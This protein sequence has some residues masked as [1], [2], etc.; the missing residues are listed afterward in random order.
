M[1]KEKR[2][3]LDMLELPH[4]MEIDL[5]EG[6]HK[7][8]SRQFGG[9]P[10]RGF[11]ELIQNALDS[12]PS[13][14]PWQERRF[15]IETSTRKIMI[16][17]YGEGL[18]LS[19][20]KLL[21]TLG[22]TDKRNDPT[23]IGT[24][25]IGF[26]SIFNPGLGTK[27]VIVTTVCKGYTIEMVFTVKNPKKRPKITTRILEKKL[28]FSTRIDVR[29]DSQDAPDQC[30]RYARRSLKYYPCSV[31]I[32]GE[33]FIS[34]WS[35][36]EGSG[37]R[38]FKMN[39][40]D[41]FLYQGLSRRNVTLLCKYEYI[42]NTTLAHLITGGHNVSCNLQDYSQK[43][44]PYLPHTEMT[45]NCNKL[46]VTISRDS[47]Y[48]NYAYSRMVEVIAR[49]L[50]Q[51]LGGF[52]SEKV[53]VQLVLAN[54]YILRKHIK[55]YLRNKAWGEI[56]K[57]EKP[58]DVVIRKLAEM[59]VYRLNGRKEGFS[60]ADIHEIQN[61]DVPL[62]F[63]PRQTNLRW[64]GGGFKHDF[65]VLPQ[66]CGLHCGAPDFY[67]T[68]FGDLFGDVV[69]LD[70]IKENNEKIMNLV[71]RGIIEKSAL[72]PKCSIIGERNLTSDEYALLDD[73]DDILDHE[74]VKKAIG[75]HLRIKMRRIKP[76]F[77]DVEG[78]Q[79][80]IATGVFNK[81][82]KAL[83]ESLIANLENDKEREG[84]HL[85]EDS[86]E[87]LLGLRRDHPL[88]TH[89]MK[90]NDEHRAYYALTFLAH[91]LALCQKLLAPYSPFY[92]LVKERLAADIRRA[93]IDQ[94]LS[95]EKHSIDKR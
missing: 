49:V 7:L 78:Q 45:I 94:L 86:H 57:K 62:F 66:H 34:I 93:M 14:V 72:S 9:T 27:K 22:G 55:R 6:W 1:E 4:G 29:F 36:A 13:D 76:V 37:A 87:I 41:G 10:G 26:F 73:I 12:Y 74:K 51:E 88:I 39:S 53:D 79:A 48:M 31:L 19:R 70:T 63:S 95:G 61:K 77:F 90:S 50:K 28:S 85:P 56:S 16:S 89:L 82:G 30:L 91:E 80:T 20:L 75:Y 17:D 25:G 92:H 67:D 11:S 71:E 21:T 64:L 2:E 38:M 68:L 84:L 59:K 81:Q 69:N 35:E 52:L 40:C 15:E 54:Q 46:R 3:V 18:G 47:F 42:M 43:E 44:V 33:P 5:D 83:S 8:I 24:F 65:I 58:E 60:L 32:N 23:K